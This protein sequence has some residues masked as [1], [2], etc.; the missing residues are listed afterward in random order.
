MNLFCRQ[1]CYRRNWFTR[2]LVVL[3]GLMLCGWS[4]LPGADGSGTTLPLAFTVDSTADS[5]QP[6]SV[7]ISVPTALPGD[8]HWHLI[9]TTMTPHRL[10]PAQR[11]VF[12]P[13]SVLCV[14]PTLPG[15]PQVRSFEIREGAAPKNDV[16]SKGGTE[17]IVSVE[18]TVDDITVRAGEI[19][20][21]K[22]H[23]S[24]VKPPA[25][26]DPRFGRSAYIHPV[27][28]VSGA[29]VTDEFP[30]DHK[31]QSGIFL[32][33]TKA[34]Y[35]GRPTNFWELQSGHGLV[36][37]QSLTKVASGPVVGS[38]RV[39]HEHVDLTSGQEKVAVRETWTCRIWQPIV[40]PARKTGYWVMDLESSML[41]P[42]SVLNLPQYHYG[43]FAV[44]GARGWMG[45]ET[46]SQTSEGLDRIAGNHTRP[47]WVDLTGPVDEKPPTQN[48]AVAGITV[49]T[50]P[51]NFRFPEPA[52]IHPKMPYFVYT[53]S[54]LGEWSINNQTPHVSCYRCLIHDGNPDTTLLEEIWKSWAE[55]A[56]VLVRKK[57]E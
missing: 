6:T 50:H 8:G 33:Y 40:D 14:L 34:E 38:F 7:W 5:R 16:A 15:F 47:R 48:V 21:L 17:S 43:G 23:K 9:E 41:A 57:Q 49:F 36:R 52:R 25:K 4:P 12:T 18:D 29:T 53:P 31:H 28:T 56:K 20:L 35:E 1:R 46:R 54:Q 13:D 11:D 32:A 10:V 24:L 3:S 51:G 55:P 26:F 19:S 39:T 27:W 2:G 45:P 42:T 37:F 30:P 44:R 22:Y